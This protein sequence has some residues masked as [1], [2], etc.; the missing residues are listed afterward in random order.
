MS[1]AIEAFRRNSPESRWPVKMA[2]EGQ[3]NIGFRELEPV[4][5]T[6][7][8][9]GGWRL[10]I[11]DAPAEVDRINGQEVW[12]WTPG[13]FAGLV[14]AEICSSEGAVR[15]LFGLDVSPDPSKLGS[16]IFSRML[17]EIR[18]ENPAL[19]LGREPAST[20]IGDCGDTTSALLQ[21][22]RLREHGEALVEALRAIREAPIR[23]ST[24]DR[25]RVAPH[26]AKRIDR[27]SILAALLSPRSLAFLASIQAGDEA[28]NAER[29]EFEVPISNET[30]DN[31]ANRYIAALVRA[32]I[33]RAESVGKALEQAAAAEPAQETRTPLALR[34][35]RR[36]RVLV[37]LTQ[38]LKWEIRQSPLANVSRA[39]VDAAGLTAV[40]AHP[41]YSRAQ[42]SAWRILRNGLEG[43]LE[44]RTWLSP[45]WEIYERWCFVR[46]TAILRQW[47]P[48]LVWRTWYGD[49]VTVNAGFEGRSDRAKVRLLLQP[50][51]DYSEGGT[52]KSDFRS[53]SGR[54]VP[55]IV[56]TVEAGDRRTF[57]VLDAKYRSGRSNVLDGMR[58]AHLYHDALRWHDRCPDRSWI[59]IPA[60][61]G[62]PWLHEAEFQDLNGVGALIVEPENANAEL[63]NSVGILAQIA[64]GSTCEPARNID[65]AQID[66]TQLT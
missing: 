19:L 39:E 38:Q 54:F 15:A 30:F 52:H 66:A 25:V 20:W 64:L 61:G 50:I 12:T 22:A 44:E 59:L 43:D 60:A 33:S 63:R 14:R 28:P 3:P 57:L 46:L 18:D 45:T 47:L 16:E 31:A 11:D 10:Y 65:M 26:L 35:P 34:W 5:F 48:S 29:V 8:S 24:A 37:E 42:V 17:E 36:Y 21:F 23:T 55:D 4:C 1:L 53:I 56:L 58:S 40:A 13:F 41:L 51:F 32:V 27:R 6:I 49:N 62:T 7:P 9:G 2:V